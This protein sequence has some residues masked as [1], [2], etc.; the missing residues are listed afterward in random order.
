MLEL[1][2]DSSFAAPTMGVLS[3]Y[4]RWDESM[5]NDTVSFS[6]YNILCAKSA[7]SPI[8]NKVWLKKFRDLIR[9]NG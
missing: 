6:A 2:S 8:R 1:C 7:H 5:E 3:P 9:S 4:I